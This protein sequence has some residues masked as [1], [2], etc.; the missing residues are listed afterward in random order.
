MLQRLARGEGPATPHVVVRPAD[1]NGTTETERN[2]QT[3]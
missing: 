1:H 2:A 3:C